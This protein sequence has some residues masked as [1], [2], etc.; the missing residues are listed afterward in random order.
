MKRLLAT[1]TA[2]TALTIVSLPALAATPAQMAQAEQFLG[3]E[4]S[5]EALALLEA[6]H[7]PATATV[8]EFFLLGLSAKLSEDLEKA[9]HYLRAALQVEPNAGRIRLELAE[10]LFRQR[11]LDESRAELVSVRSLNPPEQVL[12]N[13]AGFITQID[14][15]KANPNKHAQGPQKNWSAYITTGFTSDSN[16]NA[17]PNVDTVFL[18]GLPFTLSPEAQETSDGAWFS[19]TG[20]NHQVKLNNSVVWKSRIN[21]SFNNYFSMD[22][23]DTTGLSASTGAFFHLGKKTEVSVPITF[24]MQSYTE[25]S[26]WYSQSWG[27]APNLQ[28]KIKDNFQLYLSAS[29]THKRFNGNTN[30]DLNSYTFNPSVNLQPTKNGNIA[31]GFNYGR[32]VSELDIYTNEVRGLYLGY[33]HNFHEQGIRASITA[34]NTNTQ[35]KGI[36]AAHTVARHDES[37]KLS[38]SMTYTIPKFK[39]VSVT[40]TASH[41]NN[42]SNLSINNYERTQFS[43]S[44]TKRF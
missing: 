4:N 3:A 13:I 31:L 35:F 44:F 20:I 14:A 21:L 11:K 26:D 24:N 18:Y 17:G 2:C 16:V 36:Q 12:Q 6:A 25:Q 37:R 29:A 9:E 33:Q 41:Q 38:A 1:L 19:R 40:G 5:Q 10:V 15:A 28:Y 22:A 34:S 23:Y 8:Q 27:I 42:N 30:R 32:E 7:N 43:L 39:G